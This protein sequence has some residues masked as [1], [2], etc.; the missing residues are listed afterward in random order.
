MSYHSEH[1]E[2]T[3]PEGM[4]RGDVE[5]VKRAAATEKNM[6]KA[7]MRS[8]MLTG[9]TKWTDADYLL[10]L[11]RNNGNLTAAAK[12]LGCSLTAI[13]Y[14]VAKFNIK[15]AGG[16]GG[17]TKKWSD[18][19]IITTHKSCKGDGGKMAKKLGCSPF[20]ITYRCRLL[21]LKLTGKGGRRPKK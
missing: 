21:G 1:M 16:P 10:A 11:D 5:I 2:I 19:Q 14:R 6:I 9:N 8:Q 15:G 7:R 13:I 3:L 17:S 18:A 20:T 4:V 12:D